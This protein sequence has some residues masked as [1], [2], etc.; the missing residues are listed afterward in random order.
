VNF[1]SERGSFFPRADVDLR[2]KEFYRGFTVARH[3]IS[4]PHHRWLASAAFSLPVRSTGM[5]LPGHHTWGWVEVWYMVGF[6]I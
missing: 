3:P 4:A 5:G 6:S 1:G 2:P